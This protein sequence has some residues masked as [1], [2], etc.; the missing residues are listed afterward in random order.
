MQMLDISVLP[1]RWRSALRQFA[2]E[3]A[4]RGMAEASV[5]RLR[6]RDGTELYL[7]IA[8]GPAVLELRSEIE[9][10]KWME[11]RGIRVPKV[12]RV[13]EDSSLGAC[14]MSPV[15]GRHPEDL[16]ESPS[17]IMCDLGSGLRSLHSTPVARCPFDESVSARLRRAREMISAGVIRPEQFAERNEDQGAE[18]IYNRLLCSIPQHEDE[19]L[20]HGD[21]T[22]DNLLIDDGGR[23]GFVDCG[24]AG[25]GD[26]Y[27]D[28]A[29]MLM[30]INDYFGSDAKRLFATSYGVIDLDL[31]KLAFFSDLYELF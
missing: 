10:T 20:V 21:A 8:E 4:D 9:R 16:L 31:G 23:L 27:L 22:F 24:H 7:K 29:T 25:R 1:M 26:R 30:D 2:I 19:V 18:G 28:L 12:V 3:R 6:H 5:F 15:S 14:L 11:G 17:K 13:H